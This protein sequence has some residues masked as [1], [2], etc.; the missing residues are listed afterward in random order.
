[1]SLLLP[2]PPPTLPSSFG[3][4]SVLARVSS[5][6]PSCDTLAV[7]F[8]W[9]NQ[10]V[11]LHIRLPGLHTPQLQP[12]SASARSQLSVLRERQLHKL[13][14][15]CAAQA[16]ERSGVENE[17]K[18]VTYHV[19]E[20]AFSSKHKGTCPSTGAYWADVYL[21]SLSSTGG[22]PSKSSLGDLLLSR[23]YAITSTEAARHKFEF[24]GI[25]EF[26][27]F[28]LHEFKGGAIAVKQLPE[29]EKV[30]TPDMLSNGSRAAVNSNSSGGRPSEDRPSSPPSS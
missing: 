28:F 20:L 8:L 21:L 26:Q 16:I 23:G 6:I 7:Q 9:E 29:Q 12:A 19:V 25:R 2:S 15:Y 3:D 22:M 27:Q 14:V 11:N 30:A 10:S 1:M 18:G 5:Q 24:D 13:A 17:A 4:L